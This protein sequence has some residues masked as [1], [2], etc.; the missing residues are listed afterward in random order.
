ME[1]C[2][3]LETHE[4]VAVSPCAKPLNA[5]GHHP[6]CCEPCMK[7][8]CLDSSRCQPAACPLCRAPVAEYAVFQRGANSFQPVLLVWYWCADD[9]DTEA[10]L[11]TDEVI[12]YD[13]FFSPPITSLIN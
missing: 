6:A 12:D 4:M 8:L 9:K 10:D 2:I 11:T 1:C 5:H 7:T 13:S 3:C